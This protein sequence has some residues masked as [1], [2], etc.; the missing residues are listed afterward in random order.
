MESQLKEG[1]RGGR[2]R[3]RWDG[4]KR[5]ERR[6]GRRETRE[7]ANYSRNFHWHPKSWQTC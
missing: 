1:V 3:R 6:K 4:E 2:E 7:G 5:R